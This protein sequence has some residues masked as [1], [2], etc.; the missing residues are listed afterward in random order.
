MEIYSRIGFNPSPPAPLPKGEGRVNL[1]FLFPLL[2]GEGAQRA[3]EGGSSAARDMFFM[4]ITSEFGLKA[5]GLHLGQFSSPT[6][7]ESRASD[8]ALPLSQRGCVSGVGCVSL[9]ARC[10]SHRC[11]RRLASISPASPTSRGRPSPCSSESQP[12]FD[13][14]CFLL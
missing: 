11:P 9:S 7:R 8:G 4:P 12:S 14:S 1:I 5:T 2:V 13:R 10:T 3:G 6:V